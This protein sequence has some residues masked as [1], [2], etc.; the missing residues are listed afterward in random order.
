MV[1]RPGRGEHL[2]YFHFD[3]AELGKEHFVII[4]TR[5]VNGRFSTRIDLADS[6]PR[7]LGIAKANG[8]KGVAEIQLGGILTVSSKKKLTPAEPSTR[9]ARAI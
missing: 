7:L 3:V 6:Y 8:K 4:E 1:G 9:T 5:K 2:D